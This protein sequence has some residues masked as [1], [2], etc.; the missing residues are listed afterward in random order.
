MSRPA[1]VCTPTAAGARG[2]GDR[3]TDSG[4]IGSAGGRG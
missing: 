3:R 4:I 1:S 2:L